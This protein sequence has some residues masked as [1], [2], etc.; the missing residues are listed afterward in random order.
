MTLI[1]TLTLSLTAG[2][3][4]TLMIPAGKG[5]VYTLRESIESA[6]KE[7]GD[8]MI[9]ASINDLGIANTKGAAGK[10]GTF[11]LASL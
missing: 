9:I 4:I 2:D 10:G 5:G 1:I 8:G 7:A 3:R 6:M 11:I